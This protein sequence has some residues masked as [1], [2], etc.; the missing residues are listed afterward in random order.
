MDEAVLL[1]S[2]CNVYIR[3]KEIPDVP[4]KVDDYD[5]DDNQSEDLVAVHEYVLRH[6]SV[7]TCATV[8]QRSEQ[9]VK[10]REIQDLD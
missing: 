10:P 5:R 1:I 3:C 9:T 2:I 8:E 6:N 4:G 7:M